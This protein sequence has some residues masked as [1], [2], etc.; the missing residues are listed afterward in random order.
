MVNQVLYDRRV[1]K[2]GFQPVSEMSNTT[3]R[4]FKK[5]LHPRRQEIINWEAKERRAKSKEYSR[6]ISAEQAIANLEEK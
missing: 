4:Y 6:K 5:N 2:F 1:R 3:R